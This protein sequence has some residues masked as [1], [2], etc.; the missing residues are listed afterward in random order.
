MVLASLDRRP[1][2]DARLAGVTGVSSVLSVLRAI[3]FGAAITDT[4]CDRVES[5]LD[6]DETADGTLEGGDELFLLGV[7]SADF[8]DSSDLMDCFDFALVGVLSGITDFGVLDFTGVSV[9]FGVAL[10]FLTVAGLELGEG[11]AGLSS[12]ACILPCLECLCILVSA[13]KWC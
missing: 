2:P 6:G 4:F 7:D 9:G 13:S 12:L 1:D 3:G 11:K 8:D 5:D 10:F